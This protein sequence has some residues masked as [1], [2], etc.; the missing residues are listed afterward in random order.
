MEPTRT[1]YYF[2]LTQEDVEDVL[3]FP[4]VERADDYKM[5]GLVNDQTERHSHKE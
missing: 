5:D 3:G 1:L 4:I 2:T